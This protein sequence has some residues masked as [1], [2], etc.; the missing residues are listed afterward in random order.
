MIFQTDS[1][2]DVWERK[3]AARKLE[4]ETYFLARRTIES[5]LR[6]SQIYRSYE[7]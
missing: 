5:R 6:R 1:E 7:C 4:V 2:K 3:I